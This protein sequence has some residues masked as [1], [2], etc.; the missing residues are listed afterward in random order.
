MAKAAGGEAEGEKPI[1][2]GRVAK[3]AQRTNR[4]FLLKLLKTHDVSAK[5]EVVDEL[6]RMTEFLTEEVLHSMRVITTRYV[7]KNETVKPRLVQAGVQATLSGQ[8]R[9]DA[10]ECASDV[11]VGFIEAKKAAAAEPGTKKKKKQAEEPVAV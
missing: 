1:K 11:L 3:K 7:K 10:C 4:S 9:D 8:L 5:T 6:E 2:A